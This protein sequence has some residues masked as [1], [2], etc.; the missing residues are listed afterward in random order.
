MKRYIAN[1]DKPRSGDMMS[2]PRPA[3]SPTERSQ[4]QQLSAAA[5]TG[6]GVCVGCAELLEEVD[7]LVHKQE[8][9]QKEVTKLR[10]HEVSNRK[11]QI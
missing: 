1:G 10:N 9:I 5:A 7:H 3:R 11:V 6:A 2:E 4:S 8:R